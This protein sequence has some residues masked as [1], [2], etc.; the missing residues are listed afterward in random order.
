MSDINEE[1]YIDK[2]KLYFQEPIKVGEVTIYQPTIQ[3]IINKGEQNVYRTVSIFTGNSTT[4]RV[5]LWEAGIDWNKISDFEVFSLFLH[6]LTPDFS[7]VLFG[8]TLDFS[9]FKMVKKKDAEGNQTLVLYNQEQDIEIDEITYKTIALY[10]RHM[11][12]IFP[13]VEK[14][15]GKA[16]KEAIIEEDKMN[17]KQ[18]ENDGSTSTLLP[19]ISACCNHPGFKYK[20][21]ELREIGIYQFMDS[22]Q[23]IQIYESTNAL[24]HGMYSGMISVKDIDSKEFDFMREIRK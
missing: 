4:H 2:L 17:A 13:K 12:N 5:S 24:T 9:K 6:T 11:F 10:I 21:N 22:V 1:I 3:E 23:R 7:S 18:I 15:K 19:L 8:N 14:A 16:T 20:P